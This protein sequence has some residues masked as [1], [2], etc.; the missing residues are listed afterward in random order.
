[1]VLCHECGELLSR[2]D[3]G[4]KETYEARLAC[5]QKA[6]CPNWPDDIPV[7]D[8]DSQMASQSN[9]GM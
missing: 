1:M 9:T 7:L 4:G 6:Q 5:F 2:A 3:N 8:Y